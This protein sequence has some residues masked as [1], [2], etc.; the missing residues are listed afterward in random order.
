MPAAWPRCCP[1]GAVAE[2]GLGPKRLQQIIQSRSCSYTVGSKLEISCIQIVQS[3]SCS[4]TA[5][6]KVRILCIQ[7]VQSRSHSHSLGPIGALGF[8]SPT[9]QLRVTTPQPPSNRD[10]K[11]LKMFGSPRSRL[12]GNFL[13]NLGERFKGMRATGRISP[14]NPCETAASIISEQNQVSAAR[15]SG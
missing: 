12:E 11:A 5:G 10:Q 8:G 13:G 1:D 7:V 15:T 6:P 4:Y 14:D 3:R 9:P 2:R